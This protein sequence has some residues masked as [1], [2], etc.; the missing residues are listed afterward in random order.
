[1]AIASLIT[2]NTASFCERRR[3]PQKRSSIPD[4][5][6]RFSNNHIMVAKQKNDEGR[7][8]R[9]ELLRLNDRKNKPTNKIQVMTNILPGTMPA[10][11]NAKSANDVINIVNGNI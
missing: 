3:S 7:L 2:L 5:G 11:R 6:S 4:V 10:A 9:T 1:M 8:N